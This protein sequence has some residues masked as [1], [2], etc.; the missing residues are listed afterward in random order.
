MNVDFQRVLRSFAQGSDIVSI[1]SHAM[2]DAAVAG[3]AGRI[4]SPVT[5]AENQLCIRRIV[6]NSMSN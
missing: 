2:P 1:F 3:L 4:R 6:S 5:D